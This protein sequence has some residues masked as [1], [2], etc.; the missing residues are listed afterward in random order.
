MNFNI[1]A[2]LFLLT[3]AVSAETPSDPPSNV[4][5]LSPVLQ[6][7]KKKGTGAMGGMGGMGGIGGM[8][9]MGGMGEVPSDPPSDIPTLSPVPK[10]MG[11]GLMGMGPKEIIHN[12]R[13]RF[14]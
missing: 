14:F 10:V 13:L 2:F 4:P 6:I 11:M 3:I 8:G 12:R 9:G 1:T 7:P 5:N